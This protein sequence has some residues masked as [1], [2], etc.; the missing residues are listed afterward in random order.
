[1]KNITKISIAICAVL[2][3]N[4]LSAQPA[5]ATKTLYQ[6]SSYEPKPEIDKYVGTWKWAS[7]N[8]SFEIIL[9]KEKV[10][11]ISEDDLS[12]IDVIIGFH[13][14]IKN[15]VVVESSLQH[16]NTTFTQRLLSIY[17][18]AEVPGQIL[19]TGIDILS[20]GNYVKMKLKYTDANH[21]FIKSIENYQGVKIIPVGTPIPSSE[22]IFPDNIVLTKQ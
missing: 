22:I 16:Q 7:G 1:M 21:L 10:F 3:V 18:S 12:C 2:C 14:Y 4:F 17:G 13:K 5:N 11:D 8:D 20:N 15:G 6:C 9:K 19:W